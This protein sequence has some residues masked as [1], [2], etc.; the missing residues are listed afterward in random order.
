VLAATKLVEANQRET[1]KLTAPSNPGDYEYVCTFPG[2]FQSMWG[3]LI[4]TED[5][6]A[7]LQKNPEAKMPT[8]TGEHKHNAFE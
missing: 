5:V 2:H 7:Y 8:L 4:V 6:D 3:R 1:L